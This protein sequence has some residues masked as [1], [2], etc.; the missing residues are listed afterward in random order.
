MSIRLMIKYGE[1]KHL[2]GIIPMSMLH[3]LETRS[4]IFVK[5]NT[6]PMISSMSVMKVFPI[7]E[8]LV[9]L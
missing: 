7:T 1:E 6:L 8:K 4:L 3:A 9:W 2:Q 5:I